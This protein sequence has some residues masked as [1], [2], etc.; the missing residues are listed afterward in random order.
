R[1]Q[2]AKGCAI[3][4]AAGRGSGCMGAVQ[5]AAHIRNA[6]TS[7]GLWL[8]CGAR[9][10][11]VDRALPVDCAPRVRSALGAL[12]ANWSGWTGSRKRGISP[13]ED[14]VAERQLLRRVAVDS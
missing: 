7:D 2:L 13:D 5:R 6:D 9:R 3:A 10:I 4:A 12:L 11:P 1:R 14:T 8:A